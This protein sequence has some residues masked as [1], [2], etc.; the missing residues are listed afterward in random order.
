MATMVRDGANGP[1]LAKISSLSGRSSSTAKSTV[2]QN[3]SKT[4]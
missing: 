2:S 3:D 1:D 4:L